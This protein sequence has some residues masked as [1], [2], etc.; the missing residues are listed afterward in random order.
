VY[1]HC[2]CPPG[3]LVALRCEYVP[4]SAYVY[5]HCIC[6]PSRHML[7]MCLHV[8]E[9]GASL[10]L[11]VV[12]VHYFCTR[13]GPQVGCPARP[14]PGTGLERRAL[15]YTRAL[16]SDRFGGTEVLKIFAIY[17]LQSRSTPLPLETKHLE[18]SN[19]TAPFPLAPQPNTP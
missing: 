13:V 6:P 12:V 7:F 2:I 16:T 11:H 14:A 3:H 19:R 8:P 5:L 1:L 17:R 4:P 18:N 9:F 10:Q 15:T